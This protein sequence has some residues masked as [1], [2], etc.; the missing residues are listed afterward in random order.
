V[1]TNKIIPVATALLGGQPEFI[2]ISQG[3]SMTKKRVVVH[4]E[5]PACACGDISFIPPEKMKEKF[6]GNPKEVD[7]LCPTCGTKTTGKVSEEK[8]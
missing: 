4:A 1:I 3:G 6:I 7:I 2:L 5:C 8:K